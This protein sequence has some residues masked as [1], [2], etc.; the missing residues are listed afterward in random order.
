MS[1]PVLHLD[2]APQLSHLAERALNFVCYACYVFFELVGVDRRNN[3]LIGK[4]LSTK[5][6]YKAIWGE[7]G[8]LQMVAA[9]SVILSIV[10]DYQSH[11]IPLLQHEASL[12]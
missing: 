1:N 12:R 6:A 3:K 8:L 10:G 4:T 7:G 5:S 2:L 11:V 9:P